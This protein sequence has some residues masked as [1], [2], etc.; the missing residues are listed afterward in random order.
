MVGGGVVGAAATR[1]DSPWRRA[2]RSA[3]QPG[4]VM[5]LAL[6]G[7]NSQPS[8]WNFCAI[9]SGRLAGP[10]NRTS[11]PAPQTWQA[12]EAKGRNSPPAT[13]FDLIR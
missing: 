6:K 3:V 7:S 10:D 8:P 1:P 9:R 11:F 5:R 12:A 13:T 2:A 4:Q